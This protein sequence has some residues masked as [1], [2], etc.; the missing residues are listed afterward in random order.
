MDAAKPQQIQYN[1][2][3]HDKKTS[4]EQVVVVDKGEAVSPV[5]VRSFQTL[6]WD[7][8]EGKENRNGTTR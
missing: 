3:Q 2:E 8:P 1:G 7:V 5:R 4:Q 6:L